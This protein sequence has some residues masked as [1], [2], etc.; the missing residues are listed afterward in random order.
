MEGRKN[1]SLGKF[2]FH[3]SRI[4]HDKVTVFCLEYVS[5]VGT[6]MFTFLNI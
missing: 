3:D 1:S 4:F 5:N 6:G 2:V